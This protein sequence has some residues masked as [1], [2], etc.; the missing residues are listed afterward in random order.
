MNK[1]KKIYK[2]NKNY[3]VLDFLKVK[4]HKKINFFF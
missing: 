1:W 2:R 3:L 4:Y